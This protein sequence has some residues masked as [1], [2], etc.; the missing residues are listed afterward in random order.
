MVYARSFVIALV[1]AAG[2]GG[3]AVSAQAVEC[4][5]PVTGELDLVALELERAAERIPHGGLVVDDQNPH[6]DTLCART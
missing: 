4:L 5:V 1:A 3:H 2:A 6:W